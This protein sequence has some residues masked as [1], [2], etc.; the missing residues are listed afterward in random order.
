ML[1]SHCAVAQGTSKCLL[2]MDNSVLVHSLY[3][4]YNKVKLSRVRK[5][6]ALVL[7]VLEKNLILFHSL[8]LLLLLDLNLSYWE[9]INPE[10]VGF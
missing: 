2:L 9:H 4:P 6:S 7:T 8:H 1:M 5:P 3:N 10:G